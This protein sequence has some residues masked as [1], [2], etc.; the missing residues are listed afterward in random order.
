MLNR[1]NAYVCVLTL[2][3]SASGLSAPPDASLYNRAVGIEPNA[4]SA[5]QGLASTLVG[6]LEDMTG[7]EFTTTTNAGG[8]G[9]F[10]LRAAPDLASRYSD[11]GA[12][13][14]RLTALAGKGVEAFFI[15]SP[16]TNDLFIVGNSDGAVRL[17]IY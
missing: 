17:G 15:Y 7:V 13:Q 5:V 1:P 9:I 6:Q 4:S 16:G 10:L 3:A 11:L 8:S 2:L 12:Q 14:S